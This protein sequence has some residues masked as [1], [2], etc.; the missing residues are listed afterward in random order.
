MKCQCRDDIIVRPCRASSWLERWRREAG[1]NGAARAFFV[2]ASLVAF[3]QWRKPERCGP[4]S[5]RSWL[6]L[7]MSHA[8]CPLCSLEAIMAR[9]IWKGR[10][11]T[12]H[13]GAGSG[14]SAQ[15]QSR[16]HTSQTIAWHCNEAVGDKRI[17]RCA[18]ESAGEARCGRKTAP[19]RGVTPGWRRVCLDLHG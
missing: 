14:G 19:Q 8:R 6:A 7:V 13:Q 5:A 1:P 18:K 2:L 9:A 16:N 15:A 17:P 10:Q 11:L 4:V 12:A 3:A